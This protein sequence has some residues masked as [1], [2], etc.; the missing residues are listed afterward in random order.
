MKY[1]LKAGK[2][3]LKLVL[4]LLA[5]GAIILLMNYTF[6]K[7]YE[8]G[9]DVVLNY[10]WSD[11]E[12]KIYYSCILLVSIIA[13]F[14]AFNKFKESAYGDGLKKHI[15]GVFFKYELDD[16]NNIYELILIAVGICL[17]ILL[18][19]IFIKGHKLYAIIYYVLAIVS[20]LILFIRHLPIYK[21]YSNKTKKLCVITY[22]LFLLTLFILLILF[23]IY[24]SVLEV[25]AI[26]GIM[27]AIINYF[28]IPV[29]RVIK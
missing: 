3:L 13:Y 18:Q 17:T 24:V 27:I 15:K 10:S 7:A 19:R 11:T 28:G 2:F 23:S 26:I 16:R 25:L 5:L 8:K 9:V 29:V 21:D 20:I 22:V 4:L 6:D 1:L 12:L 14:F